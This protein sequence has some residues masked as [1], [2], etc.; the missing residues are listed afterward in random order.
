MT[1]EDFKTEVNAIADHDNE[2][3]AIIRETY[4]YGFSYNGGWNAHSVG[5][6][7]VFYDPT[8]ADGYGYDVTQEHSG[9][10]RYQEC[11]EELKSLLREV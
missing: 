8:S 3:T 7:I 5:V 2:K 9:V 10:D 6:S 1:Y 4:R 11:L